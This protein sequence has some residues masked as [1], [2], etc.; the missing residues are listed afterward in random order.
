MLGPAGVG[1]SGQI[2]ADQGAHQGGQSLVLE[3]LKNQGTSTTLTVGHLQYVLLYS[4][5]AA[6]NS[7]RSN[8]LG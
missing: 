4:T 7:I 8:T 1:S 2:R 6:D 5:Q 3:R